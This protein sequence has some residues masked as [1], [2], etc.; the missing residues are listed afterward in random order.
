MDEPPQGDYHVW[1]WFWNKVM[2]GSPQG[3]Y[4]VW[5]WF[6]NDYHTWLCG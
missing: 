4:H 5:Y 3:D 1:Y 6:W 2:D